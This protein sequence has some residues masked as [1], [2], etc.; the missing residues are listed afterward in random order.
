M[1][2]LQFRQLTLTK[3]SDTE[4]DQVKDHLLA[5]MED[6]TTCTTAVDETDEPPCK[7]HALDILL[8]PD[9]AS[10]VP[11]FNGSILDRVL[12]HKISPH[13]CGGKI[14]QECLPCLPKL[15]R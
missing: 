11:S 9:S 8:G 6:E 7:K 1:L 13:C 5:V 15:A 2:D 3:L 10:R 12:V 14:S 4:K